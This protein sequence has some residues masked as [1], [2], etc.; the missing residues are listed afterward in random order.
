VMVY[1]MRC[2]SVIRRD[3]YPARSSRSFS[4]LPSPA[5][6]SLLVSDISRL[7]RLRTDLCVAL[8]ACVVAPGGFGERDVH[9]KPPVSASFGW[10]TWPASASAIERRNS[11]AFAGE[12]SR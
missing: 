1:T 5:Y 9:S 11:R 8:P 6:G 2:S 10:M 12:R 3:Q 4:G 7:I